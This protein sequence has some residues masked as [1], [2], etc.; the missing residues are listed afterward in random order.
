MKGNQY[1]VLPSAPLATVDP[2]NF[3]PPAYS[4]S[5][6]VS[7]HLGRFDSLYN[8]PSNVQQFPSPQPINGSQSTDNVVDGSKIF[9]AYPRNVYCL[10][11][12]QTVVTSIKHK[13]GIVTWLTS[14]GCCLLGGV[15][16]C[17]L[18]PCC[19][20]FTRDVEHSCSNCG[21]KVGL[22]RRI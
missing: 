17:F 15:I 12:K 21:L 4:R 18:I 3:P 1:N 13:T 8:R 5:Q 14:A 11:C 20:D 7:T 10:S 22:Y 19:T 6:R 9:G 2:F 16:G